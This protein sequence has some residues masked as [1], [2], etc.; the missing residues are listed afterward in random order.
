MILLTGLCTGPKPS[1]TGALKTPRGFNHG[2][3]QSSTRTE[4]AMTEEKRKHERLPIL[5][6]VLWKEHS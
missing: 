1:V 2:G 6:E 3:N 5:V 4:M